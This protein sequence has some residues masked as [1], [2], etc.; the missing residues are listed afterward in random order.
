MMDASLLFTRIMGEITI[1]RRKMVKN[2]LIE[3]YKSLLDDNKNP[4]TPKWFAG[5]D[6]NAAVRKT[7]DSAMLADKIT[8]K[9]SWTGHSRK[10]THSAGRGFRN[11]GNFGDYR[12][13]N[14]RQDGERS[15]SR[16]RGR[17]NS[18]RG[19]SLDRDK[20]RRIFTEG[21]PDKSG[22]CPFVYV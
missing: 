8:A 5:D 9:G 12:N 11:S 2:E 22:E 21:T 19:R 16:G 20:T 3:P 17:G 18:S 15:G 4:A 7:K 1:L 10:R 6:I 13:S 14:R